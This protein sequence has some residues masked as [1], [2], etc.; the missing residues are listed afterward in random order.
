MTRVRLTLDQCGK[1]RHLQ[2]LP[3]GSYSVAYNDSTH[4]QPSEWVQLGLLQVHAANIPTEDS[5]SEQFYTFSKLISGVPK[6]TGKTEA[7]DAARRVRTIEDT[8]A[9]VLG[10]VGLLKPEVPL[11]LLEQLI[12]LDEQDGV[13]I[14]PD[15]N[16]LHNG[17]VHWLLRV[18]HR[19]SIWL[20]PVVASLTTIQA[21]D[22]TIKSLVNKFNITNISKVLRSR[23]LVNGA[24]GLLERNKG[25]CQVVEIDPSLLRYQKMASSSGS[26]P[27]Q[28][29]VLEDRLIIEAIHNVL[30][31]MR[32]RTARRVV[33]SDVNIARV[34]SAEGIETLFV[35]SLVLGDAPVECLRYD[36]LARGFVGAPLRALAWEL[37]HAFGTVRI[38]I[39]KNPV[40]TLECYWPGKT[41]TEWAGETLTCSF[42]PVVHEVVATIPDNVPS[43]AAEGEANARGGSVPV[44]EAVVSATPTIGRA[45]PAAD[46]KRSRSAAPKASAPIATPI[47]RASLPQ[48]LRMLAAARRIGG[49]TVEEIVAA[50]DQDSISLDK[51]KRPVEILRRIGLLDQS[52]TMF[53]PTKDVDTVE[54]ALVTD[55]LDA[56]SSIL[57]RWEA[58]RSFLTVLKERGTVAR[59]EIVP[60][61]HEIVGRAG[62]EES[63][64]LPRFHIL[65][66]Q[67]WSN[68]DAI[69]DGS[70]R[71]T[72]R[73]ATDAFEQAFVEVSSVGI[74]KVID[75]L[76]RFC[77]LS[78][79]SPWAAKQRLEKFVAARSLPD[80]TFQ[81]AAGG[82]PVSR[83]EAITGPLDKVRTEPVVIDRLYLGERPVLT[84]EGP[85]R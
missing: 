6:G 13:V 69:F 19:P 45:N 26:D 75:L 5:S 56:V 84:V 30:R 15:T 63:E 62:L 74:A 49:G 32:S 9:L 31:S 66:G 23:G 64:R 80:Y 68:G 39:A 77:E 48:T 58:Y 53:R 33:T 82:K 25:R 41:P 52:G 4:L 60:L 50:L 46:G 14:V 27:D 47:P 83:D 55:D 57:E 17:S 8:L 7:E 37:T 76:P 81:P 28:S 70:N 12:K 61:V 44:V 42:E 24:L 72:D 10:R 35:P 20:M 67:A 38:S 54:T 1:G 3:A 79:M 21:R 11:E 51:A 59:Q 65:L 2:N 71:P 43:V 34:L 36:A 22:A 85:A 29:D 78:R 40:A 18:L 16:A 73:D